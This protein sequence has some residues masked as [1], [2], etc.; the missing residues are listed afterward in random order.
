MKSNC[1]ARVRNW[2]RERA[3]LKGA[4]GVVVAAVAG[5]SVGPNY[6]R[7]PVLKSQPVPDAFSDVSSTNNPGEWKVAAPSANLPRGEWWKIFDD[8]ELER[9]ETLAGTENQDLAAATARLE[10][11]RAQL[12]V[13]RSAFYPQISVAPNFTRQRTSANAPENGSPARESFIYNTFNVPVDAGWEVDLWGRVR[14]QVESA[15][16]SFVASAD[17]L[18]SARLLLQTEVASDYFNLREL[19]EDRRVVTDTIEA[20]RRSLELTQNR[21]KGGVVSD[22]DVSQAETQ[23]RSTEAELPTIDLQRA[24]VLHALAVL[25]G[26]PA[27]SFK[28]T[29]DPLTNAVPV[30][31][32]GVPSEL[33]ERRPDIA[34]AERRMAAANAQI[35]V[36]VSA[37]YPQV[38]LSG[39]AGYQSIGVD[40]LFDWPSRVWSFGPSVTLPIFTGG[41]N[42]SQ[43]ALA[44]ASF[45][46][47]VANY[48]QTVL[49][50]F[51]DVEDQLAA[52]HL[53]ATQLAAQGAAFAAAEHTLEVANNRYK[54]GLI[55][56]LDVV[57]S[58]TAAL[59]NER[60]VAQIKGQQFAA[61][62][63]LIKALGGG[64]ENKTADSAMAAKKP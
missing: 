43:L 53:L 37:F 7:P 13:A 38:F 24:Q 52:E 49:S 61:E 25:C 42:R 55:T 30:V 26:Q 50:A 36:A 60:S 63:G 39:A 11:A 35:G 20:Y 28:L 14:R 10:E 18:E 46:E 34:A 19:M 41:Q 56:Y 27:M 44:R 47:T 5:C 6:H 17:D 12:G 33:L 3:G 48:R 29:V 2:I 57:T 64:W 15:H 4:M 31:P 40:T 62:V 21:R 8:T 9:L 22:L 45:D 54:A 51:Q 58:Q 32:V 1:R 59:D 23:L 16:A